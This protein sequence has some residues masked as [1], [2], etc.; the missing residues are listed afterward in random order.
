MIKRQRFTAE[1]K[2]EAVRLLQTAGKPAAV[3]NKGQSTI[4]KGTL[5]LF[6][7]IGTQVC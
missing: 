2:H 1:F 6:F 7:C 5:T 3:D 4:L